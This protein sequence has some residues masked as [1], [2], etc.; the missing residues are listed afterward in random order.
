MLEVP[1]CYKFFLQK[2]QLSRL[3]K[4]SGN[5]SR[6]AKKKKEREITWK[7]MCKFYFPVFY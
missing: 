4:D 6:L 7:K 1:D 3:E 2:F 5:T